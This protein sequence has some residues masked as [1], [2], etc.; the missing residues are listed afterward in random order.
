VRRREES[1][2]LEATEEVLL[3]RDQ[4]QEEVWD[5]AEPG[6][7]ILLQGPRIPALVWAAVAVQ[8]EAEG[9]A[10]DRGTGAAEEWDGNAKRYLTSRVLWSLMRNI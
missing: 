10:R 3:E 1:T 9:S 4:E 5:D 7:R 6:E 2:C 8:A